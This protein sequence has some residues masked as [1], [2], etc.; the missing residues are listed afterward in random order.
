MIIAHELAA[1]KMIILPNFNAGDL[2]EY[3][4]IYLEKDLKMFQ[5][6]NIDFQKCNIQIYNTLIIKQ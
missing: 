1:C 3:E 6:T 2:F 5:K 4:T